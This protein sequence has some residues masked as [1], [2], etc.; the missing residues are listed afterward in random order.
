MEREQEL[1]KGRRGNAMNSQGVQYPE[2]KFSPPPD[3]QF[4][5]LFCFFKEGKKGGKIVPRHWFYV[6]AAKSWQRNHQET[7]CQISQTSDSQVHPKPRFSQRLP[8]SRF[9]KKRKGI[10]LQNSQQLNPFIIRTPF[11]FSKP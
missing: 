1:R 8:L 5:V 11:E 7:L 10:R 9:I 6:K 4:F 3:P 2:G